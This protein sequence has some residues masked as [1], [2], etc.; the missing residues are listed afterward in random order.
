MLIT[1]S[2]DKISLKEMEAVTLMNR[3][4]QKYWFHLNDM[5]EIINAIYT[6]YYILS[7]NNEDHL[8][9]STTY[10]DT[11]QND[12]F[13]QHHNGKLNRYKVRKRSYVNSGISFLEIK[14][15]SNKG[16]T[17]KKRIPIDTHKETFDTSESSFLEERLPYN[18]SQLQVA[19]H[20]EFRRITL[21]NKN[22]KERCTIDLN[23]QF[24]FGQRRI[25]LDDMVIVEIKS[26]GKPTASPLVNTLRELRIKSSGFSKYCIGKSLTDFTLKQNLFKAKIRSIY[27]LFN[28]NEPIY[29]TI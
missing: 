14:F 12:M 4:D 22:F 15:K 17:I 3:V 25:K 8:P 29:K 19:L 13:N 18:V 10:F 16:R 11:Y 26:D 6:E 24:I 1:T 23:L 5:Q 28:V 2:F 27:K 20:N 7:I 21:V 9:Y